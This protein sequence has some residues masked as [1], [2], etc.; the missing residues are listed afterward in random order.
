MRKPWIKY[1]IFL[2]LV[3]FILTACG[4]DEAPAPTEAAVSAPT[5]VVEEATTATLAPPEPTATATE[6]PAPTETTAPT[7][8]TEPTPTEEAIAEVADQCLACHSD[9]EQLIN[10][11]APEEIIPSESSGVG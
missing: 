2:V 6:E 5:A 10:T 8:T 11:A 4:E 7:P 1:T 9:K 3:T